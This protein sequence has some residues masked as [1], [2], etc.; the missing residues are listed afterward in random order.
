MNRFINEKMK[1]IEPYEP[2][3]ACF[4]VKLDANENNTPIP[5]H[6]RREIG[7]AIADNM[8]NRY[9]DPA[10]S[11]LCEKYAS[12]FG[13]SPKEIVAGCGSDELINII[14]SFFTQSGDALLCFKPDFS[15][16]S[17]YCAAHGIKCECVEKK[18][19]ALETD[20]II[21]AARKTH[22]KIIIFSNPCNPTGTG[23]EVCEIERLLSSVNS[24]VIV[25][26]AYMDFWDQSAIKLISKYDNLIVLRTCSKAFAMAGIRLGFAIGASELIDEIKKAKSPYNVSVLTQIAASIAFDYAPV[27]REGVHKICDKR[28]E[29][30]L[31]ME[32]LSAKS[33]GELAV[34]PSKANFIFFKAVRDGELDEYLKSNGIIIRSFG[35]GFMRV[36]IG[37]A[38]EM[39]EFYGLLEGFILNK[40]A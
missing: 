19:L 27:L 14:V 35:N 10:S 37:E 21:E 16:Y 39:D 20:D 25:D 36:S 18:N 38:H 33:D 26:E 28:D 34:F 2:N 23:I 6:I 22:P 40:E 9:P 24:L 17:F 11:E 29:L 8:L 12:F 32:N 15:M 3:E 13:I 5:L 7:D 4:R 30:Y 1:K 31:K